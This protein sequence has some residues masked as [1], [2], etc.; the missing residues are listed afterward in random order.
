MILTAKTTAS[1]IA[2]ILVGLSLSDCSNRCEGCSSRY[3]DCNKASKALC[4]ALG[5]PDDNSEDNLKKCIA[6]KTFVCVVGHK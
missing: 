5:Y 3:K 6:H 4:V 1:I 2:G